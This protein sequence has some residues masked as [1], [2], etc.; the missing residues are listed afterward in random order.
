MQSDYYQT[1]GIPSDADEKT[2]KDAYRKLAFQYHPDRNSD[3]AGAAVRMKSV[4]EAYA[5]LSHPEKRREY[6]AIRGRFGRSAAH[7]R[8][9]QTYS[10][11]DIFSGSDLNQV[12]DEIAKTFGLRGFEDIFREVYGQGGRGRGRHFHAH[13]RGFDAKGYVFTGPVGG[14]RHG[15]RR[16]DQ[17]APPSDGVLG[18]MAKYLLKTVAGV[19][20]PEPGEDL[21]DRITLSPELA[22]D[23]GPY[24]YFH[25]LNGKKLVVRVPSGVREGQ[26]IRLSGMGKE[27]K[28]G[29]TPG[30]LYLKVQIKKPL[31]KRIKDYLAEIV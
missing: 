2:I 12:L 9:R 27:G 10:D 30:D 8:F 13:G 29:G 6:D 25:R 31:F 15:H 22:A 17:E 16:T 23:G 3:D 5:V 1:L 28:G 11:Q 4:N 7:G 20:L 26:R 19:E 21:E 14:A 24:A 18:K